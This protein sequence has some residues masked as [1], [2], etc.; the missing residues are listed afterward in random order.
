[1]SSLVINSI[2]FILLMSFQVLALNHMNL[3]G[4]LNPYI[5]VLF[6][7][8]LP[9]HIN[10]SLLL[11]LG[12]GTGLCIDYFGNTLGLHA[13]ATLLLAFM[14][15]GV[16]QLFFKNLDFSE[17]ETPDISRFGFMGF[18]K[19]TFVLVIFHHLV[20]FYLESLSFVGFLDTFLAVVYSSLLSTTVLMIIM[21]IIGARKN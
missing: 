19:Y 11:F 16:I 12:F 20:L 6:I 3:G 2:R 9:V 5:Y 18:A 21:L 10:K 8:L 4:Y 13:S 14:R 7:M 1:M 15:P 17:K